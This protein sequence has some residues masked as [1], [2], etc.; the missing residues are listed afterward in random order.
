MNTNFFKKIINVIYPIRYCWHIDKYYLMLVVFSSISTSFITI[1]NVFV[2]KLLTEAVTSYNFKSFISTIVIITILII[3]INLLNMIANYRLEPFMRNRINKKIQEDIYIKSF[4]YDISD[5]D[6]KQFF[7]LYYFVLE[8]S[9][10]TI[11]NMV[12]QF[13]VLLT[14]LFSIGGIAAIVINY[15]LLT[16]LLVFTGVIFSTIFSL[17]FQ[18]SQYKFKLD[19]I[20]ALRK[21]KYI[22]RVFYLIDYVKEVKTYKNSD[23]I[24]GNYKESWD[25]INK[26]THKWVGKLGFTSL[27][28]NMI[29]SL[30]YILILFNLG[31]QTIIGNISLSSFV[32]VFNG[33][34]Q[35]TE[36]VKSIISVIPK[37]YYNMINLD[38][39]FDYMNYKKDVNNKIFKFNEKIQFLSLKNINFKYSKN[40]NYVLKNINL[41]IS[42]NEKI[43]I[44]GRNGSGKS[45]LIKL[46]LGL[47]Q[48]NEG[49]I[50]INNC[51]LKSIDLS[52][53]LDNIS[54]V[55]QDFQLFAFSIAQNI[56]MKY[57]LTAEDEVI[58][59]DALKKV[60]LYE[61]IKKLP[62][63][64]NTI[65]SKEFEENGQV[66]S[67]GEM[68]RLALARAYAKK[69]D[70]II[71]DE[72]FSSFDTI[73]EKEIFDLIY[74]I[75]E[76]KILIF[77]THSLA[78]L[79][80]F[81]KIIVMDDGEVIEM[82]SNN[83]L[84]KNNRLYSSMV[85]IQKS[86]YI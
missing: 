65:I 42:S 80:K 13:S 68:Q 39:Y 11:I 4:D 84:L 30:T 21:I 50:E 49:N 10:E 34:K 45:T 16:L 64:I 62:N 76:N 74:S 53:Y 2:L 9:K 36:Q 82:G 54:I 1:F 86:K 40:E 51:E 83:T 14:N 63:G 24:L 71:M 47:Y 69:S 57:K 73:T 8:N 43:A 20:S 72:P 66:F 7:D 26:T 55:Y 6:N 27:I 35:L 3:V 81:D 60:N 28:I 58:V 44:V 61:K 33:A 37:I 70:M 67:G 85:N 12:S 52:S 18:N 23:L 41:N 29:D 56:S 5:F 25:S 32:V 48:P 22:D 78:N 31:L 15:D 79:S 77:I 38:K 19:T 75:S 59:I 46:I 17:K